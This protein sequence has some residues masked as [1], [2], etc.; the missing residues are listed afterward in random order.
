MN[1]LFEHLQPINSQALQQ[2]LHNL[3]SSEL[4]KAIQQ[5]IHERGANAIPADYEPADYFPLIPANNAQKDLYKEAELAGIEAVKAGKVA[6]FTVA[7]GQGTRLGYN[8]PK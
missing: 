8:G 3:D 5:C 6:A 1:P 7:G 2:Q 4:K